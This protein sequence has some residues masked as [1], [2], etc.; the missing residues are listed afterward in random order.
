M[1]RALLSFLPILRQSRL[2]LNKCY[3]CVKK[4]LL[5]NTND[6]DPAVINNLVDLEALIHMGISISLICVKTNIQDYM[7]LIK[8]VRYY[9]DLNFGSYK[10]CKNA[11]I[12]NRLKFKFL[13][14]KMAIIIY[15]SPLF[16]FF[17]KLYKIISE[18]L[19][20][21]TRW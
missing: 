18:H 12:L 8:K 17:L 14:I 2:P 9:I 21:E 5:S 20:F 16:V 15:D 3:V 19:K 7:S 13:K 4:H 11:K 10:K 6:L 1:V